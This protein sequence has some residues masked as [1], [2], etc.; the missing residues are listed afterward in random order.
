MFYKDNS[1]QRLMEVIQKLDARDKSKINEDESIME[2]FV[3]DNPEEYMSMANKIKQTVDTL[4]NDGHYD[5]ID[6]L[7]RLLVDRK[8]PVVVENEK[9]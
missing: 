9:K 3:D 8:R 2:A 1:K 5:V 7:Y 6:T 4:F